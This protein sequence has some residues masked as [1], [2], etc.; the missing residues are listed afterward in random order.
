MKR[1][2]KVIRKEWIRRDGDRK[3]VE[4]EGKEAGESRKD[5]WRRSKEEKKM[6]VGK[7]GKRPGKQ[8]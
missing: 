6:W 1:W 3:V 5:K 4:L 2:R 7:E 8:R